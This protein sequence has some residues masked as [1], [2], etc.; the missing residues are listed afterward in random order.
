[1]EVPAV[2]GTMTLKVP[3]STSD[4]EI[5]LDHEE[6]G[7]ETWEQKWHPFEWSA[8]DFKALVFLVPGPQQLANCPIKI[9][10]QESIAEQPLANMSDLLEQASIIVERSK[11]HSK[12]GLVE[13]IRMRA[14][15]Y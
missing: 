10:V 11:C 13:A 15:T 2:M 4:V 14:P 12:S 7:Y 6:F 3:M 1:M 9:G 8:T 5:K